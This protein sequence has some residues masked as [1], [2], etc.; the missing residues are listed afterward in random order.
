MYSNTFDYNTYAESFK[1]HRGRYRMV[2]GFTI[3]NAISAY[4]H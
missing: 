3:A 1:A 2:L 4:H